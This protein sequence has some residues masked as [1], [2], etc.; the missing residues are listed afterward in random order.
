[1]ARPDIV[2]GTYVNILMGDGAEPEVFTPLCGLTTR[3]FTD[4]IN[5]NDTFIRDCADPE[6]VPMREVIASGRQWDMTGTGRWNRSDAERI[7]AAQGV[8]KNYRFEIGEPAGD[9]VYAGYYAGEAMQTNISITGADDDFVTG[10]LA[11][12]SNGEWLWTA[13]P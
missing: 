7:N 1:M 3:T 2:R 13:V 8:L 4:Q 10:D 12:A 5:T 11:F 9:A 6:E